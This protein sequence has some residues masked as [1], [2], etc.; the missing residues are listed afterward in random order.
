MQAAFEAEYRQRYSFLMRERRLVV[1]SISVEASLPGDPDQVAPVP[2]T[3]RV[4]PPQATAR[5]PMFSGGTWHDTP[6]Y[7]RAD[8]QAGDE[9]DGPAIIAEPNQT[10]VV[11]PDWRAVLTRAD[12]WVITRSKPLDRKSTRLNSSH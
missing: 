7:N 11:E 8:L 1:E 9:I 2:A 4:G 6:I 3:L 5:R 12:H 10:I